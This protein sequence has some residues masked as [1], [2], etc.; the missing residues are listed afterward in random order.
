M[1][2]LSKLFKRSS[3][4]NLKKFQSTP[5]HV[6]LTY[7]YTYLYW[8]MYTTKHIHTYVYKYMHMYLY[9]LQENS[10]R[11]KFICNILIIS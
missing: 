7:I 2:L 10:F 5:S 6:A 1:L 11:N 3:A 8:A 9:T 4:E